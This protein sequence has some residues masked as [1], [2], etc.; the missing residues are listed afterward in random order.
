[1]FDNDSDNP[2]SGLW[3]IGDPCYVIDHKISEQDD[4]WDRFCNVLDGPFTDPVTNIRI[5][6]ESTMYGDGEYRGHHA[7]YS[8]DAGLIGVTSI[9]HMTEENK[10]RLKRLGKIH[11]FKYGPQVHSV[12][13]KIMIFDGKIL[14]EEI[15]TGDE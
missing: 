11:E 4:T 13:G 5:W 2:L 10:A 14:V 12:G 15:E 8:V 7:K 6:A 3:F 9:S 1:M